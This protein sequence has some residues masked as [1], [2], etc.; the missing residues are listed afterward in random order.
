MA[1]EFYQTEGIVL[2]RKEVGEADRMVTLF[3]KDFGLVKLLAKGARHAHS[4]LNPSLNLF[5]HIRVAF[6]SGRE[7][8]HLTD[9]EAT[10]YFDSIFGTE[11]KLNLLGRISKFLE[12][13]LRPDTKETALWETVHPLL[14]FL[15]RAPAAWSR[16]IEVLFYAKALFSLGHLDERNLL[17]FSHLFSNIPLE[18]SFFPLGAQAREKLERQIGEAIASSGL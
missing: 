14:I 1:S 2:N 9:A 5:S 12:R 3:T 4:K 8:W 11:E 18:E 7:I 15:E 17:E 13:F 16:D 10:R 6:V